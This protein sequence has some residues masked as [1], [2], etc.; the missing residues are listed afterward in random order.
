MKFGE[1][2]VT[3]EQIDTLNKLLK[4]LIHSPHSVSGVANPESKVNR[5]DKPEGL[6]TP[7][8]SDDNSQQVDSNQS[9][10]QTKPADTTHKKGCANF[11]EQYQG[12]D[13]EKR[14]SLKVKEVYGKMQGMFFKGLACG[15]EE[16]KCYKNPIKLLE[17]YMRKAVKD[18][19]EASDKIIASS[20]QVKAE[21]LF[22]IQ[23]ILYKLTSHN[24]NC[25][26][27]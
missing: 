9:K 1:H 5:E 12:G 17:E 8:P 3:G 11:E 10:Q 26:N 14:S 22:T 13:A 15:R 25:T 6:L 16:Q 19:D 18:Y 7:L 21:V 20:K 24:Q 4:Q 2:K 23:E 27:K